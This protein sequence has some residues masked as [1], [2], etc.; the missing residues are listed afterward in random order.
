MGSC[1]K[2]A[3]PAVWMDRAAAIQVHF[4]PGKLLVAM[5][6]APSLIKLF[7]CCFGAI[8]ALELYLLKATLSS[9]LSSTEWRYG[10]SG[11]GAKA[12]SMP[13]LYGFATVLLCIS[14]ASKVAG[15]GTGNSK[16]WVVL[17]KL[18]EVVICH[19]T[20]TGFIQTVVFISSA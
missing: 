4:F 13:K 14:T 2:I 1:I 18:A 10:H 11:I 9:L 12:V 7:W 3:P 20:M 15:R 8:T 6:M 16:Q 17:G 19:L 5:W